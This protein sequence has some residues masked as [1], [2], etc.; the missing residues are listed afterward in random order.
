MPKITGN[1]TR[2]ELEKKAKQDAMLILQRMDRTELEL[3]KKLKEKGY[4][5]HAQECAI[6]YVKC[7]HYIDDQRYTINYIERNQSRKG[8]RLMCMELEQKGVDRS[9]IECCMEER[10]D[11]ELEAVLTLIEKKT[12]GK[13]PQD[14][15]EE[16]RLYS[17][18]CRRGF[19]FHTVKMAI[20]IWKENQLL[21]KM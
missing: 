1:E 8:K 20:Q 3:R 10:E 2:E 15:K 14:E 6:D 5:V 17:Y 7:Y 11:N 9:I 13:F 21:E 19:P 16:Q 12:K 4:P 18:C